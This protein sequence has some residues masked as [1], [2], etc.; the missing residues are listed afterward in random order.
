MYGAGIASA[1]SMLQQAWAFIASLP[2]I[3]VYG[4]A[5]VL[6]FAVLKGLW[7]SLTSAPTG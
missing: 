5:V 4:M 3:L 7:Q 6:G 1:G 2:D